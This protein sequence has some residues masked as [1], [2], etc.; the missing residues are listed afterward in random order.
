M[1]CYAGAE[2]DL[3]SVELIEVLPGVF[4]TGEIPARLCHVCHGS[5]HVFLFCSN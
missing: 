2:P 3:D 5:G 4:V 1:F